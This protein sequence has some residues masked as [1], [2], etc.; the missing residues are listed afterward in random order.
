MH[1]L[2]SSTPT[3]QNRAPAPY[4]SLTGGAVA[5]YSPAVEFDL[6]VVDFK[7]G[8]TEKAVAIKV[9]KKGSE[10][11]DDVQRDRIYSLNE[12]VFNYLETHHKV[13]LGGLAI[14]LTVII[15]TTW[16]AGNVKSSSTEEGASVLQASVLLGAELT[17]EV[18]TGGQTV[19]ANAE[20]RA[21]AVRAQLAEV[22][23]GSNPPA[24]AVAL[25]GIA[26]AQLGDLESALT[27]FRET[28]GSDA[29]RILSSVALQSIAVATASEGNLTQAEETLNQLADEIPSLGGFVALELARLTE[30]S[31]DLETAYQLY[32]QIGE[33]Q[34]DD[35]LEAL[36]ASNAQLTRLAERRAELLAVALGIEPEPEPEP[37]EE[38]DSE[39]D[40]AQTP[41]DGE[42]TGVAPADEGTGELVEGSGDDAEETE[43]TPEEADEDEEESEEADED[44]EES[45]E[46]DEDEEEEEE[47]DEG[48]N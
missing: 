46:A 35:P 48:E 2:W 33:V 23:A 40:I 36:A 37:E 38:L 11:E 4:R 17:D 42:G 21:M 13:V 43:L 14:I 7:E 20:D 1:V 10:G 3:K 29:S 6:Y 26:A 39:G 44:E 8:F 32:S 41:G 9:K 24:G 25:D 28:S 19:F 34:S 47:T 18:P 30:A 22:L 12:R 27:R 45:E 31:G 5:H 15:A 16:I